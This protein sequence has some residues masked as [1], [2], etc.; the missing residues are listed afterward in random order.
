MK[1]NFISSIRAKLILLICTMS[2]FS[3]VIISTVFY[4]FVYQISTEQAKERIANETSLISVRFEEIF[5]ITQNNVLMLINT[6]PIQGIIRSKKNNG[7]DTVGKST[8]TQWRER[9]ENIF[10]A[11]MQNNESYMQ[12][13]YIGVQD[14]GKEIVRVNKNLEKSNSFDVV[15]LANLQSKYK[16]PYFK[17]AL[18]LKKG[19]IY[20]SKI[21][22]NREFG[23]ISQDN[24][25]MSRVLTP[26][27]D[28]DILFGFIVIN[29]NYPQLLQSIA[30]QIAPDK[31]LMVVN[32][33]GSYFEY[34]NEQ[35]QYIF[36]SSD[37]GNKNQ[38]FRYKKYKQMF[39]DN[40][41]EINQDD[42][43]TYYVK[44]KVSSSNIGGLE[45]FITALQIRKIALFE[46]SND[47]LK[48][49]VVLMLIIIVIKLFIGYI[50]A[51]GLIRPFTNITQELRDY[52]PASGKELKLPIKRDD[53]IGSLARAFKEM[54]NEIEQ[55]IYTVSHDL[56]QPLRNI[57][58]YI[59]FIKSD[60]AENIDDTGKGYIEGLESSIKR[61]NV[62]I[63]G[64]LTYSRIGYNKEQRPVDLNVVMLDVL[65]DLDSTIKSNKV[66]I[67]YDKLPVVIGNK[68]DLHSLL[69][70]LLDNSIKYR[71][72][73]IAPHI[74]I[75]VRDTGKNYIIEIQ[76]NGIGIEQ[77]HQSRVF[78][79]FHRVSHHDSANSSGIGLAHCKKIIEQHR[80]TITIKSKKGEGCT[81]IISF[82]KINN[83]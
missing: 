8:T 11:V 61:M 13:R 43:Y 75:S 25:V 63:S 67:E 22:F 53:E 51:N 39:V 65:V 54:F 16:E 9:L 14:N 83:I 38:I 58:T 40:E 46:K 52:N 73:N 57:A 64:L 69:Q 20:L 36:K 70:N 44:S 82:P 33:D 10:V 77:Q 68:V 21:T 19:D 74:T 79:L 15:P 7:I 55:F 1:I 81:F 27:Y 56:K 60:Y 31:N 5:R 4:Y 41:G 18:N 12:I 72:I 28:G 78:E 37:S 2:L 62:L 35:K 24:T 3:L 29:I 42:F 17:D 71:K 26:V 34:N 32:S 23:K 59:S 48:F 49:I 66:K 30:N 6:P 50:F 45:Y 80:G 76:D 47:L